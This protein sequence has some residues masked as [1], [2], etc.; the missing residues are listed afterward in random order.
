MKKIILA[1]AFLSLFTGMT[2]SAVEVEEEILGCMNKVAYNFNPLGTKDNGS[3][4]FHAGGDPM[5]VIQPLWRMTG[6]EIEKNFITLKAG[7]Q[8]M[9]SFPSLGVSILQTCPI[10]FSSPAPGLPACWT[11]IKK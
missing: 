6:Y 1:I 7:E 4:K 5:R 2:A 8:I 11:T 3:C 9:Q 10:W